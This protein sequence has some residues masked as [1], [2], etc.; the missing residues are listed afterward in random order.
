M[1]KQA[2][3]IGGAEPV[4]APQPPKRTSIMARKSFTMTAVTLVFLLQIAYIFY[5]GSADSQ[6]SNLTIEQRAHKILKENPLIG[7]TPITGHPHSYLDTDETNSTQTA[8]TT[9]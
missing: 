2:T 9:Y 5:P 7:Q 1:E 3:Y 6:T 4:A 8:T